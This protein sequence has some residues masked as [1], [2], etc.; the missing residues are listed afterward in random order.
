MADHILDTTHWDVVLPDEG[1]TR[2]LA[3]DLAALLAPGDTLALSGD[4]GAGK[5][6]LARALVRELAADDRLDVP[7]PTFTL[8]QSYDLARAAVVH[9]DLYRVA[10]EAELD[11]IGWYEMTE[12]AIVLVEWPEHAGAA[13]PVE[14]LDVQLALASDMGPNVRRA[15]LSGHG[16]FAALLRRVRATRALID[17]AGFGPSRRRHLLGDASTRAY[18]RLYGA[19]RDAIL[20]I[21]PRRPDGPPVRN[22]LPYSAIAHLAEDVKPFIALARGLKA[23]GFSAPQI[24]AADL[25]NGLLVLED[26]GTEGVVSGAPTAPIVERYEA[27]ADVLA[28]LHGFE[29][30]ARLPVGSGIDHVIPAYD[31]EA[32]LIE[33]E[34]L[35]DWYLPHRGRPA[36][37]AADREVFRQLWSRVLTLPLA[38]KPTWVLRDY[39]SPNLMWLPQRKGLERIGLLDF[40]D[41]V[42]GPPAYDLA[43]LAQD[44]RL[45]VPEELELALVSRYAKARRAAEPAFDVRSFAATY[46]ILGAQRATKILGIFARLK[47]RDGKPHY[48]RHIPRIWRYLD[49]CLAFPDLDPLKDWYAAHVPPP[50]AEAVPEALAEAAR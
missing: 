17:L 50:E 7:S 44:A 1:A 3:M 18:E 49:R 41:A 19:K 35:L 45:D 24:Y 46:A 16:R 40:Q 30:P 4:L 38:Q 6:T 27:A 14:R 22:G 20:M 32:F 23:R 2:R 31:L 10:D 48:L 39:H 37:S 12:G 8:V 26:L 33:V 28:A 29:L 15:R 21:A 25:D 42:M 47:H 43:S 13:L 11:E 9:A 5:T 34:L 36:P